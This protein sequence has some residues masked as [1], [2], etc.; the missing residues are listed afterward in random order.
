MEMPIAVIYQ[1]QQT[2]VRLMVTELPL[3]ETSYSTRKTFLLPHTA[4][5]EANGADNSLAGEVRSRQLLRVASSYV[6]M[7]TESAS[8]HLRAV[9]AALQ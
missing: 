8:K 6:W 3:L 7:R 1:S 4:S 9:S 5:A 2:V